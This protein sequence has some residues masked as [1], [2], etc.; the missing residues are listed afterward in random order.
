MINTKL[1]RSKILIVVTLV[2]SFFIL[3]RCLRTAVGGYYFSIDY[4][5]YG[6][7][8]ILGCTLAILKKKWAK[9]F[10]LWFYALQIFFINTKFIRIYLHVGFSYGVHISSTRPNL[11]QFPPQGVTF[12]LVGIALFIFAIL[13]SMSNEHSEIGNEYDWKCPECGTFN[14]YNLIKCKCGYEDEE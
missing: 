14:E 9:F 3:Y 8:G 11:S 2:F 7:L 1:I 6:L 13:T 5:L 12:N 4:W 10:I